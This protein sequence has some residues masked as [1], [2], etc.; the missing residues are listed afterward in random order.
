[1]DTLTVK[2]V[3]IAIAQE[4]RKPPYDM[5]V[6]RDVVKAFR[7]NT[8]HHLKD[9]ILEKSPFFSHKSIVVEKRVQPRQKI[10][11]SKENLSENAKWLSDFCE[12]QGMTTV[13]SKLLGWDSGYIV[14]Y[15]TG[16]RKLND[17]VLKEIQDMADQA[18]FVLDEQNKAYELKTAHGT[19]TRYAKGCRCEPCRVASRKKREELKK[20]REAV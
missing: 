15:K 5:C 17:I 4:E 12:P 13:L 18:K 7:E 19:A 6:V 1:M 3:L 14:A 10:E 11:R 8:E 16:R 20:K 9:K 2:Q